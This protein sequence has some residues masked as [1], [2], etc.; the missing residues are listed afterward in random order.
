VTAASILQCSSLSR[1]EKMFYHCKNES[2]KI[3]VCRHEYFHVHVSIIA[4]ASQQIPG[5]SRTFNLN[6]QDFPRP[7][8]VTKTFQVL[9]I[10]QKIQDFPGDVGTLSN[11][12]CSIC[13]ITCC[14]TNQQQVCNKS[15]KWIWVSLPL[16]ISLSPK[17][18]VTYRCRKTWLP[19]RWWEQLAPEHTII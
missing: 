10:L 9:K 19:T 7:K 5:L 6:F 1:N 18:H 17:K 3:E 12:T 2:W 13:W 16:F 4:P 11:S 14:T 15:N 8:S